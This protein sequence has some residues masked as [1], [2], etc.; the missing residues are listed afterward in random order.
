MLFAIDGEKY[1]VIKAMYKTTFPDD[2]NSDNDYSYLM[3]PF[4]MQDNDY[5]IF[6][7]RKE[8]KIR[9]LAT[10]LEYDFEQSTHKFNEMHVKETY[11]TVEEM[12]YVANGLDRLVSDTRKCII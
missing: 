12:E 11:I 10:K 4:G 6:A 3:T 9:L 8:N 7:V 1:T 5:F 2:I